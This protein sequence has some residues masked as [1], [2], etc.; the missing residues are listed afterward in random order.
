[1]ASLRPSQRVVSSTAALPQEPATDAAAAGRPSLL[2]L[3]LVVVVLLLAATGGAAP[4]KD[5]ATGRMSTA[6]SRSAA[7]IL[8]AVCGCVTARAFGSPAALAR[9]SSERLK[10]KSTPNIN[11]HIYMIFRGNPVVTGPCTKT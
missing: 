10:C 11:V 8:R 4:S 3:V 1:V 2:V 9:V 7:G 6:S 5:R